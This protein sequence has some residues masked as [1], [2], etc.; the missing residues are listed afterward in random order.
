MLGHRSTSQGSQIREVSGGRGGT[1]QDMLPLYFGLGK[2]DKA[3]IRVLWPSG[4]ECSFKDVS[5]KP[6]REFQINEIKC[7]IIAI[8]KSGK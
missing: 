8:G 2:L 3:D 5:V 6:H 7:D 4:K 1:E